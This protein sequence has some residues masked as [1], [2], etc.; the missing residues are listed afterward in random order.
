M[1][2]LHKM[3]EDCAERIVKRE[4][5]L[6]AETCSAK[7]KELEGR[8]ELLTEVAEWIVTRAGY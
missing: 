4:R 8:I 7:R 3:L 5:E 1:N 2:H 6:A